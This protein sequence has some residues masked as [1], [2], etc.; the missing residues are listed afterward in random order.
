MRRAT[1]NI[2]A[3]PVLVGAATTLVIVVGVFLA[4]NANKGLPFV[5]TFQMR[6]EVPDASRL[7]I[8]ND[9]REGGQRIGQVTKLDPVRLKGGKTGAE[10]TLELQKTATPIPADSTIVIR[11]RSAL[12]SKFVEIIRGHSRRAMA[13]GTVLRA[14]EAAIQVEPD[15]VFDMFTPP[16]RRAIRTNLDTFGGGLVTRGASINRTLA[17]LPT[18]LRG[19]PPVMRTLAAPS[20]RLAPT[21]EALAR[22]ASAVAPVAGPLARGFSSGADVFGA[23]SRDPRALRDTIGESPATLDAAHSSF[24]VQRPFLRALADVSDDVRATAA[25]VRVAAPPISS[26]LAA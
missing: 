22:T 21:I 6:V 26:A 7:V 23:L 12:G 5:P 16:T 14:S 8:G 9:V 1:S 24:A 13:Q 17:A 15:D 2:V 20:T 18:L 11:P 3:N 19:L 10:L 25:E 4:Y